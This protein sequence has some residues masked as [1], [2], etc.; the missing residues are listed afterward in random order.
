MTLV[1]NQN[2][3]KKLVEYLLGDLRNLTTEAKKKH[4]H[5]KDVLFCCFF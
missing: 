1:M 3:P 4:N 2:D 5:V